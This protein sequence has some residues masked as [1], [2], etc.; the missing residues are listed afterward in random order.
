MC[1]VNK[2]GMARDL[3]LPPPHHL[4]NAPK[5][6]LSNL[7]LFRIIVMMMI[8]AHHYVVNSGLL[9]II[10]EAPLSSKSLFAYLFGAWGK[11]GINCFVMITGYFMCKSD[12]SKQKFLKLLLEIYFYNIIITLIFLLSGYT[13]FSGTLVFYAF[14]PIAGFSENFVPCY[15][16]FFLC[17]PYLNKLIRELSRKQHLYFILLLLFV[18]S[19]IGTVPKIGTRMN[20]VSWFCV[21]YLISSYIRFYDFPLKINH[22]GWLLCS[23]VSLILSM[24]SIIAIVKMGKPDFCYFF[25]CDANKI[26]SITTAICFFM[27]FKDLKIPQSKNLNSIASSVFGVLLIHTNSIAMRTWLWN[28][29]IDVVGQYKNSTFTTFVS[30]YLGCTILIYVFCTLIDQIRLKF[31]ER[32][33]FL[34]LRKLQYV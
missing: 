1:Y 22:L 17:I 18:F 23:I 7:E 9:E 26:M 4:S 20:Y 16:F 24:V 15:L 33:L 3:K 31:V 29:V 2:E 28:D 6:R 12:I 19:I 25:I 11:T 30:Y 21:V 34:F 10:K 13:E 27:W 32:P 8:V 14:V 5:Q